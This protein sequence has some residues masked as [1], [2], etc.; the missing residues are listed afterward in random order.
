[1]ISKSNKKFCVYEH[2]FPNGKRYIGITSKKPNQRW[3]NGG[4][5]DKNHQPVM[6]NAIQKY[7]WNNIEHNILFTDLTEEEAKQKEIELIQKY[8][9]YI[10]DEAPMGYNMT[11]GGEGSIGHKMTEEAKR[12]MSE[13][14]LGKTGKDC[15]NSKP[16]ICDGVE[17]E[18]L[19]QFK[20]ITNIRGR[21][22]NWLNGIE[23]MPKYWYDKGLHYKDTDFSKIS[24][25]E[26]K[27]VFHIE[28]DGKMFYSQADFARYINEKTTN[29]CLWINK[30]NPMPLDLINR[31]LKVYIDGELIEF[32]NIRERV[33]CWKYK[34]KTFNN[35]RELSSYL[36]INKS[37]LWSYIKNPH[38][39]S[40]KKFLP[41]RDII[42][43]T[44]LGE[45]KI[46]K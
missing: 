44:P 2:V 37:K 11:L 27:K 25:N 6:W 13:R 8:H 45:F 26:N 46:V 12:K 41:L 9:T 3:E 32:E 23:P 19:T 34:D 33:L 7:G 5:Y 18:S 28:I 21:V 35:L 43:V 31:G 29:V 22:H 24:C 4:G 14:F 20:E 40:A 38:W 10:H 17:Y 36:N 16:I 1:M 30:S 39:E 15:V 42:K